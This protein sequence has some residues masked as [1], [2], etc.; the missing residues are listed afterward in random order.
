MGD[1]RK[2]GKDDR[3]SLHFRDRIFALL[4]ILLI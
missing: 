1:Y 3:F 2:F 4:I